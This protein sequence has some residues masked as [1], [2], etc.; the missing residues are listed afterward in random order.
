MEATRTVE[1]PST[2]DDNASQTTE[3]DPRIPEKQENQPPPQHTGVPA[4][5]GTS[6]ARERPRYELLHLMRGHT[7]SI[8]AVKFSLDGTL[9]ASSGMPHFAH[10]DRSQFSFFNS[11]IVL[12]QTTKL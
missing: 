3:D 2:D 4:A 5:A 8:S 12:K 11:L 9:L 1:D 10:R 7:S 6:G